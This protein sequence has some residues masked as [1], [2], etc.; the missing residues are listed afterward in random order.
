MFK[1]WPKLQAD[2]AELV[3]SGHFPT[4]TDARACFYHEFGHAVGY[5]RNINY[6]KTTTRAMVAI[7]KGFGN[8]PHMTPDA[9]EELL[10]SVLS[11]YAMGWSNQRFEEV[12]AECFAEWYNSKE[13]RTFCKEFLRKAGIL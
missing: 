13:P 9:A 7:G 11:T 6:K 4:G 8:P 1:D 2:Y 10:P 3:K 12:I 5:A